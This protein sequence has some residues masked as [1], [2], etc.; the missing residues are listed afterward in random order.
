MSKSAKQ[1]RASPDTIPKLTINDL[2]DSILKIEDIGSKID[3]I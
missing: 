3:E 1:F 2:A